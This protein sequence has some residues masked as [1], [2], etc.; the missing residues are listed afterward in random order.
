M[1]TSNIIKDRDG[2]DFF[3]FEKGY[4]LLTAEQQENLKTHLCLMFKVKS[5]ISWRRYLYGATS[6]NNAQ[7]KE[8]INSFKYYGINKDQIFGLL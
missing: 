3:S 1:R 2:G 6:L 5:H 7:Y 8:I 4:S